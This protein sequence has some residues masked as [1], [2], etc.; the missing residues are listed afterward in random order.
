MINTGYSLRG[1]EALNREFCLLSSFASCK[2]IASLRRMPNTPHSQCPHNSQNLLKILQF[3][4]MI[5]LCENSRIWNEKSMLR[6]KNRSVAYL[7]YV[8]K[9]FSSSSIYRPKPNFLLRA[10]AKGLVYVL[11]AC[12]WGN[13]LPRLWRVSGLRGWTDT[14]ELRHGPDSYGR[15]Q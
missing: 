12:W 7:A 11:S 1:K 5:W 13:G 6:R 15:Q 8:S 3:S 2:D 10:F 4:H 9:I 14:L